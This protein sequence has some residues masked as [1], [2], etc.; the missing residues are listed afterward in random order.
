MEAEGPSVL[1]EALWVLAS[2]YQEQADIFKNSTKEVFPEMNRVLWK[3]SRGGTNIQL[4]NADIRRVVQEF[5]Q[6]AFD[7]L[8]TLIYFAPAAEDMYPSA[9]QFDLGLILSI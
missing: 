7:A 6:L 1:E 3:C 5:L 9:C 8:D 4:H 2:N